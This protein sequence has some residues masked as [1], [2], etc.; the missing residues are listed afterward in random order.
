MAS[1]ICGQY[2]GRVWG[3][4]CIGIQKHFCRSACLSPPPIRT[5]PSTISP[6]LA[7]A[8]VL[9]VKNQE[10]QESN[11]INKIDFP[12][13]SGV[14]KTQKKVNKTN[15]KTQLIC[16]HTSED[17]SLNNS[18]NSLFYMSASKI[19]MTIVLDLDNFAIWNHQ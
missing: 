3:S 18:T 2:C 14:N 8:P 7:P 10:T 13:L 12:F 19:D 16:F 17:S 1:Q 11:K 4:I 5:Y 9:T 6:V 15:N